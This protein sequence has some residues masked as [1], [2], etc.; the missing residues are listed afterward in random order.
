MYKVLAS[1]NIEHNL[2][3]HLC[4]S[5]EKNEKKKHITL[6]MKIKR[7]NTQKWSQNTFKSAS[8]EMV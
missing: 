3:M 1:N 2:F 7:I 6:R 4:D 5:G 8:F